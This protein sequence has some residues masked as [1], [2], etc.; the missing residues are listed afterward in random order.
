MTEPNGGRGNDVSAELRRR[1]MRA[2][3]AEPKQVVLAG[4]KRAVATTRS[5]RFP[6]GGAMVL[7][8]AVVLIGALALV[9]VLGMIAAAGRG[10]LRSA[11]APIRLITASVGRA[12][13]QVSG[14]RGELIV[15]HL[16]PPPADQI[17]QLWLQHGAGT[18]APGTLFTVTSRGTA[19][20]GLPGS[21][22]GVTRV[23]VT[24]EPAGGRRA[25]TTRP[26]IVASLV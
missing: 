1:V 21:T 11:S 17:Y 9:G 2:V 16:P 14:G 20:V 8:G 5:G 24:V 15:T 26:V 10:E 18:P 25:P 19:E 22:A 13:L 6:A 12:R 4:Q 3:R 7:G 23:L